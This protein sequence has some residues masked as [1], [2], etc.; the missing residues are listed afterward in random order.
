MDKNQIRKSRPH[1]VQ[2]KVSYL[3]VM[4]EEGTMP[5]CGMA[6]VDHGRRTRMKA[7]LVPKILRPFPNVVYQQLIYIRA[8][9]AEKSNNIKCSV[10]TGMRDFRKPG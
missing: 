6:T 2:N 8:A 7:D 3:R 1:R 4:L 10:V 9:S 5:D